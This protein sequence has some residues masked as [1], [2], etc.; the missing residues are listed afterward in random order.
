MGIDTP[1]RMM[2]EGFSFSR[3]P[4]SVVFGSLPCYG[5][6]FSELSG[7]STSV[8]GGF[9]NVGNL[10]WWWETSLKS[11]GILWQICTMCSL[12]MRLISFVGTGTHTHRIFDT[13]CRIFLAS[14]RMPAPCT[15]STLPQL[16]SML[17]TLT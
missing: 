11:R 12:K 9:Q 17:W 10:L 7:K 16:K 3:G 5:D 14:F 15:T 6:R 1:Q 13:A 8:D 2:I 4:E